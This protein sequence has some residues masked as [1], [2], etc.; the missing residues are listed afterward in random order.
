MFYQEQS[1]DIMN[2]GI[3]SSFRYYSP[4]LLEVEGE[5]MRKSEK[6]L[7]SIIILLIIAILVILIKIAPTA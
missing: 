5:I 2:S 4:L 3:F 6:T 7:C 1:F